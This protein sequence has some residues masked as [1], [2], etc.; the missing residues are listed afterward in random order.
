MKPL[1]EQI[2]ELFTY[3]SPVNDQP[4]RYELI[5]TK[6]REFAHVICDN[7]PV[8]PDQSASIRL[9]REAVMTANAAI[10]LEG[11]I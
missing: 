10:A 8:G 6:A 7:T 4:R 3:H 9:L 5:R 2:D 1:Q 11:K